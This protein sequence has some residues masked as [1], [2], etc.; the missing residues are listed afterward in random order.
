MAPS[1]LPNGIKGT[2]CA[3]LART[4]A[5]SERERIVSTKSP[6][7]KGPAIVCG[8][9]AV[10]ATVCFAIGLDHQKFFADES[11]N[12]AQSYY[13][14]LLVEQGAD[15]VDWLHPAAIDHLPV[16]KYLIGFFLHRTG[17]RTPTSTQAWEAWIQGNHD[18]P[19]DPGA[20]RAARISMMVGAVLACVM[21][22]VLGWQLHGPKTG[23]LAA[24][25]L[26][27]SPLFYRHARLAMA[28]CLVQGLVIS[29]L[30]AFCWLASEASRA[31]IRWRRL[32]AAAL[33]GG[34]AFGLAPA[35]KLNGAV[36]ALAIAATTLAMLAATPSAARESGSYVRSVL[37]TTAGAVLM[38]IVAVALFVAVNPF[39]Y[40]QTDLPRIEP[41]ADGGSV[42][43]DGVRRPTQYLNEL[44]DLRNM[45]VLERM[46]HML[47]HRLETMDAASEQFPD[48]RLAT[49]GSRL[50]AIVVEGMGRW[51]A[52]VRLGAPKSITG[53]VTLFLVLLGLWRAAVYGKNRLVEGALPL[54]WVLVAWPLV[55]VVSLSRNLKVDWDR[56]Y[57]GVVAWTSLLVVFGLTRTGQRI[58]DRLV[59]KPPVREPIS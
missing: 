1:L 34:V 36:G 31:P 48:D 30:A 50:Q 59:L 58:L 35:T 37:W 15:H 38:G 49:V 21:L 25:L 40:A 29:G 32:L 47:R 9:V 2:A 3:K 4:G 39:F 14:R 57:M 55:E 13:Y 16:Y 5:P 12:I 6:L 42:V 46:S 11:A 17:H 44:S 52:T 19:D 10:V 28:D 45:S 51:F 24:A 18:P 26:A 41:S 8:V 54:S 20:L 22:T 43:V 53:C 7:R 23:L 33:L 27:A 56:Y